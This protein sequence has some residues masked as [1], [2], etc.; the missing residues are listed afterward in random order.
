MSRPIRK[1][2]TTRWEYPARGTK[3]QRRQAVTPMV[4]EFSW[5]PIQ[6]IIHFNRTGQ[7]TSKI[8]EPTPLGEHGASYSSSFWYFWLKGN[9]CTN[10]SQ[11]MSMLEN[12]RFMLDSSPVENSCNISRPPSLLYVSVSR[13]GYSQRVVDLFGSPR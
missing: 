12:I 3:A 1:I 4:H 10:F 8:R 7:A 11:G 13:A 2:F 9:R 5:R 6:N